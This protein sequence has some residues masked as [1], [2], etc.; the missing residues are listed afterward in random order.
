MTAL[1]VCLLA[2]MLFSRA[3]GRS[4]FGEWVGEQA[5]DLVLQTTDNRNVRLSDLKGRAVILD[6]WA[7]WCGPCRAEIPHFVQLTSEL[8]SEGLT[9]LGISNEDLPKLVSFARAQGVNYAVG[10]AGGLVSPYVD[11]RAIPTTFFIDRKG[12]IRDVTVGYRSYSQLHK[13]VATL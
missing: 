11:V 4:E 7:T 12:V 1:V 13:I 10:N 9:V 6:F 8:E 3:C 2:A 5:P